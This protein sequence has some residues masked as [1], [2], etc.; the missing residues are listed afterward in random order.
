MV[1]VVASLY[2]YGVDLGSRQLDPADALRLREVLR[3]LR[4]VGR[5]I[6][7]AADTISDIVVKE[8]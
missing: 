2:R 6:G 3:E 5:C 1:N 8:R 7:R 4:Q